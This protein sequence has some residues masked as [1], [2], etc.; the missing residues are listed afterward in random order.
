MEEEL[1]IKKIGYRVRILNKL[2]A[3][4]FF[5]TIDSKLY[6]DKC[7]GNELHMYDKKNA[8]TDPCKCL[9]F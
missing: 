9:I 7:K 4:K 6:I 8:I 3:G 1:K 5:F 2:K